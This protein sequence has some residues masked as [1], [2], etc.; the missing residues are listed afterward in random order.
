MLKFLRALRDVP[1]IGA[2]C[3]LEATAKSD[4]THRGDDGYRQ[5]AP[6]P[7]DVLGPISDPVRGLGEIG[8]MLLPAA[9]ATT[10]STSR[11]AQ[12]A[13]PSPESTT[14]RKLRSSL[15]LTPASAIARNIAGSS[16]FI[17]AARLSRT[18]AIPSA[19]VSRML[20]WQDL[21]S[22]DYSERSEFG[23]RGAGSARVMRP[24][25]AVNRLKIQDVTDC[26]PSDV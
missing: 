16:A 18:S 3:E 15:S 6:E 12:K 22:H 8:K 26:A 21:P 20:P 23:L 1:Q 4:A 17:L 2:K 5:L 14:A 13:R 19:I 24:S 11:P 7:D 25:V 9:T 10:L